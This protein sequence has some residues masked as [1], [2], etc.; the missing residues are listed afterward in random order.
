MKGI[1]N[2]LPTG[3]IET[4]IKEGAELIVDGRNPKVDGYENGFYLAPCVFDHVTEEMSVGREEIFGPVLCIKRVDS[5]EEGLTL[6]NSSRFANGSVIYTQ[7]GHYAREFAK[8]TDAGMVGIN[9]GIPVPLGI[10]GFTGHKE[11][12][13]GDLHVMGRDGICFFTESKCVTN[14]WFPEDME[15][16]GKVDTWDGTISSMPNEDKK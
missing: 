16:G 2:L 8:R 12:F 5:F 15:A 14:T 6:M 10:F 9:V 11:S 4:G 1:L 3:W 13:F 7:N